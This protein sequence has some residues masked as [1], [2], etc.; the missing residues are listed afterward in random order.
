MMISFAAFQSRQSLGDLVALFAVGLL[1]IFLRRFDWSRPAFLI[2]FVLSTQAENFSFQAYQVAA[3]KFRRG[4]DVGLEYVFSNIVLVLLVIT[5][6]S[7]IVGIRQAKAIMPEG[8]V[9]TGAKRAPLLFLLAITAYFLVSFFNAQA[10]TLQTD[11]IFPMTISFVSVV[12]CFLL[13]IK[14]MR[15]GESDA[16]FADREASGEDSE[17]PYTLWSTLAWFAGLL[18]LASLFGFIIA[19]A[20]F[21]VRFLRVRAGLGWLRTL[22]FSGP[23]HCVH[24]RYGVGAPSR[25]PTGSAAIT[26]GPAVAI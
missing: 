11:R 2:G 22:L 26:R 17:A 13:L 5:V 9:P 21:L 23:G 12:C 18:V 16:I 4:T 10:I 7:I 24:A 25:L 15:A 8:A 14:M 20:I 6:I 3:F 19:L 1:G